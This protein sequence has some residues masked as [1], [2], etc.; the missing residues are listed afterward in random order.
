MR[1]KTPGFTLIELLVVIA[2]IA[3]L[4]AILFPVF[5][6]ARERARAC[7]C[8]SNTKQ[9]T[10]ALMMYAQDHTLLLPMTGPGSWI[11]DSDLG[12][13]CNIRWNTSIF[14]YVE[15]EQIFVCPGSFR[16]QLSYGVSC[17][18]MG[19]ALEEFRK[20]SESMILVDIPGRNWAQGTRIQQPSADPDTTC[21]AGR[22][23]RI[24]AR[25]NKGV[26]IGFVDGHARW[27]ECA[28]ATNGEP[29]LP[30]SRWYP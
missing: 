15:N 3:I 25:H 12:G 9:L 8:L 18:N 11:P 16:T 30:G 19:Y 14:P 29:W 20:P 17:R 13:C 2:I 10:M 26:N 4:A 27:T 6:K 1:S 7:A 22:Y 21:G 28:W 23:Q 5:A 24:A